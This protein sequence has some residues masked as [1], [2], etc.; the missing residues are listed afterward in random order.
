MYVLPRTDSRNHLSR[1]CV[2]GISTSHTWQVILLAW[3]QQPETWTSS[4]SSFQVYLSSIIDPEPSVS[5][6]L[7][8]CDTGDHE[9]W[10]GYRDT[11]HR[12]AQYADKLQSICVYQLRRVLNHGKDRRCHTEE[13]SPQ[14]NV[15]RQGCTRTRYG[16]SGRHEIQCCYRTER[17][18]DNVNGFYEGRA[19]GRTNAQTLL[20]RKKQKTSIQTSLP[21]PSRAPSHRI[22]PHTSILQGST[23]YTT[24]IYLPHYTQ[25]KTQISK[26]RSNSHQ[27][28]RKPLY[29]HLQNPRYYLNT[30]PQTQYTTTSCYTPLHR[31]PDN[32]ITATFCE[33]LFL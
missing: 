1:V 11:H 8:E 29:E 13:G 26:E 15:L 10:S 30:R 2:V 23:R 9:R 6:D 17:A 20:Q 16:C 22:P 25:V 24:Q 21:F 3:S 33:F 14:L 5:F 32:T 31:N 19:E 18:I 28:K 27:G 7:P 12:D 4:S